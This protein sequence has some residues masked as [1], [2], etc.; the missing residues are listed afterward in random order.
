[1]EI[2]MIEDNES[3]SEMM[4]MFFLNEGWQATFKYDGK[5]GLDTFLKDPQKYDLITLDLNLP[6]MDGMLVAKEIRKISSV[7]IIMLTARDSESDQVIGLEIGADDYVTKPFSPLTLIARIKALHRRSELAEKQVHVN[8][9]NTAE[10]DVE[11]THFK[12]NIKTREAYL[13]NRLIEGLTPKEFDLLYTM[14]KKPRQVFTREQL[15]E[16]VWDY[17]YFGDE[18][19]V[20]AHIKK[21]RQKIEKVGPQVIQTVWGV[22][23]KFD[24]SGMDE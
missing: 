8:A 18:R 3:V 11:T 4:Q 17:Q 5:E 7:P 6:G 2:L 19:T 22:G 12:M 10:F 9:D 23:Y 20:D 15:L 1:M 13:N 16:L 14:A 24:D 21:L